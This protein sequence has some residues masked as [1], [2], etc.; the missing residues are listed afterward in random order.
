MCQFH[1]IVDKRRRSSSEII[2]E[3]VHYTSNTD[4]V[5]CF[6]TYLRSNNLRSNIASTDLPPIS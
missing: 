6:N 1:F 3:G 4:M 5:E 2:K